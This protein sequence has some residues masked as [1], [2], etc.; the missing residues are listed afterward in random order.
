[1]PEFV[2]KKYGSGKEFPKP[3]ELSVVETSTEFVFRY[4][5]SAKNAMVKVDVL[6]YRLESLHASH[7]ISNASVSSFSCVHVLA[8]A[9]LDGRQNEGK[10]NLT[11]I[12]HLD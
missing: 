11:A 5:A 1:M 10:H 12:C 9:G 8:D 6:L 7:Q 3:I 2:Q 4:K